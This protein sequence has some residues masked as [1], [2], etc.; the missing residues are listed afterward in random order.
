MNDLYLVTHLMRMG[1]ILYSDNTR[2][3]DKSTMALNQMY[4]RPYAVSVSRLSDMIDSK[5]NENDERSFP[6]KIF[7]CDERDFYQLHENLIN[8]KTAKYNIISGQSNFG[9]YNPGS[10]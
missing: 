10:G 6:L 8:N 2:K 9:N 4:K 5:H 7:Q 3:T 1:K